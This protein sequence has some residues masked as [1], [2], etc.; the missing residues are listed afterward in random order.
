MLITILLS[1]FVS[2]SSNP[3]YAVTLSVF[4]YMALLLYSEKQYEHDAF[5]LFST[6]NRWTYFD[7]DISGSGI[8]VKGIIFTIGEQQ[9]ISN[10]TRKE[11]MVL[12]CLEYSTP[13]NSPNTEEETHY[14][15]HHWTVLQASLPAPCP[16]IVID[17]KQDFFSTQEEFI[18]D[19][20]KI[21]LEGDFHKYFQVWIQKDSGTE[22]L[23]ILSPDIMAQLI[24][25]NR[26]Y[27]IELVDNTAIFFVEGI[28]H[29]PIKLKELCDRAALL[30]SKISPR[31]SR[32]N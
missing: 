12:C 10:I 20:E 24:D 11:N 30:T 15:T 6:Q 14:R 13:I 32:M 22:S 16:H 4:F 8:E 29:D 21:E 2:A 17:S 18:P 26:G 27:S 23:T 19:C 25:Y 31:I 9:K 28:L 5:T 7:K 1:I 3:L